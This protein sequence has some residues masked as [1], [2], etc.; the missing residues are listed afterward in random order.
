MTAE[1]GGVYG[2][3]RFL[4]GREPDRVADRYFRVSG[5]GEEFKLLIFELSDVEVFCVSPR[6]RSVVCYAIPF[7]PS[8]GARL[9]CWRNASTPMPGRF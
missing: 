5:E 2:S 9:P 7:W 3:W 4:I 1:D 8:G 6:S